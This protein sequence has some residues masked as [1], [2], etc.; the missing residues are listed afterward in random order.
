MLDVIFVTYKSM[1]IVSGP[2]ARCVHYPVIPPIAVFFCVG[3]VPVFPNHMMMMC[4]YFPRI[5]YGG[6]THWMLLSS[7]LYEHVY[8]NDDQPRRP[9]FLRCGAPTHLLP[10]L[11]CLSL[12]YM[13]G[14]GLC[15]FSGLVCDLLL[16]NQLS[17]KVPEEKRETKEGRAQLG[18]GG[19]WH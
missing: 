6:P 17:P 10:M 3:A 5:Q 19:P 2:H 14:P 8:Y 9:E 15:P 4:Q 7:C 11:S 1:M 16:R 13:C 18:L 12:L